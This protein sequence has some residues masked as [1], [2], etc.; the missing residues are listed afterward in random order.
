MIKIGYVKGQGQGNMISL[1]RD[2]VKENNH[3]T[4][5]SVFTNATLEIAAGF[6]KKKLRLAQGI[7]VEVNLDYGIKFWVRVA[8]SC[9]LECSSQP[10]GSY[11]YGSDA[12]YYFQ[13]IIDPDWGVL[14]QRI[15]PCKKTSCHYHTSRDE[16]VFPLFE[17][18]VAKNC[19]T[20]DIFPLLKG[21]I[22]FLPRGIY[23][24]LEADKYHGLVTVIILKGVKKIEGILKDDHIFYQGAG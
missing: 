8:S 1:P 4:I 15:P 13:G 24:S 23:H 22:I 17:F 12:V 16:W 3:Y 9:F 21:E 11:S 2:I 14:V 6:S 5:P 7:L 19:A 18:G 10:V 20:S